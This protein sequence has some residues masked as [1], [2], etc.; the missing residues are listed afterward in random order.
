MI[1]G[2]NTALQSNNTLLEAHFPGSELLKSN[3]PKL[4]AKR[5]FSNHQHKVLEDKYLNNLKFLNTH[6][7][8]EAFKNMN[9]YNSGGPD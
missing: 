2:C 8:K 4:K 6:R 9:P 1:E 5:K 3:I 7:V